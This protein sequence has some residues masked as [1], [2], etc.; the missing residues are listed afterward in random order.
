[1][2]RKIAK[3]REKDVYRQAQLRKDFIE[4]ITIGGAIMLIVLTLAVVVYFIGSAQG[5][6]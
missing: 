5:K 1:M 3:Q 6:W 2:R 4:T